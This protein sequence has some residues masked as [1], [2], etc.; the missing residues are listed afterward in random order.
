MNVNHKIWLGFGSVLALVCLGSALNYLGSREA[1]SASNHLVAVNLAEYRAAKSADEAIS[2]ARLAEQR[3]A[4]T[5]DESWVAQLTRHADVVKREMQTV[6]TV[7][8]TAAHGNAARGVVAT[9]DGYVATFHRYHQLLVRRGLTH[10]KGLEGQ[11]RA[12]VHQVESK[13]KDLGQ[14]ELTVILLMARR[15]EKDYLLRADTKYLADVETR[16]KEF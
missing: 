8:P 16:L 10:E 9:I 4:A 15:H 13:A 2:M 1:E 7:T 5:S 12:A 14:S 3:F 6:Q 11:L